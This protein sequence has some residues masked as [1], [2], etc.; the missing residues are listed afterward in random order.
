MVPR[1]DKMPITHCPF[2]RN[3][4]VAA[5]IF[6]IPPCV[7]AQGGADEAAYE[8][9]AAVE[10]PASVADPLEPA[11]RVFFQVNDKLY[12]WLLK[13]VARGYKA[14]LPQGARI[15][16]RNFFSN[17]STPIRLVNCA[18]QGN[19]D[20]ASTELGRF[21]VNT[22]WG[23]GGF[24]DPAEHQLGW[25][26][27]AEDTGQTLGRY[28]LGSGVFLNWPLLGPS[29]LRDT[30][31][32]VGDAILDPLT[33]LG[34]PDALRPALRATE[35]VNATSLQLGDYEDFKESAIDPYVSMRDAYEQARR[36]RI[37]ER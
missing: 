11:N 2:V 5:L 7:E 29:N 33:Y 13:P 6:A 9:R 34:D 8:E 21:A 1:Q 35:R 31:G 32:L 18:L 23:I 37:E 25:N 24:R 14:V 17:V 26:T 28:G 36:K 4:A 3:I 10:S 22:T 19:L 12:F 16:I 20:G 15:G 30:V 27:Q